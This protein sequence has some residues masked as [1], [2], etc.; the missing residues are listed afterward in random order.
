[1][2]RAIEGNLPKDAD[3]GFDDLDD[4]KKDESQVDQG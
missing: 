2:P 4:E 1:V 3:K